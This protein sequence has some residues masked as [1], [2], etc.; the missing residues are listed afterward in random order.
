MKLVSVEL[1]SWRGCVL[2]F[3]NAHSCACSVQMEHS[4]SSGRP[5]SQ[6][7]S[8]L[9][10][11]LMQA[12]HIRQAHISNPC[13]LTKL[14]VLFKLL[15]PACFCCFLCMLPHNHLLPSSS[16]SLVLTYQWH[17]CC[18]LCLLCSAGVLL[19]LSLPQ[20]FKVG[21]RRGREVCSPFPHMRVVPEKSHTTK[22]QFVIV[23]VIILKF[24]DL[25]DPAGNTLR[26]QF[27]KGV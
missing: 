25:S 14:G 24:S 5:R 2:F 17:F 7:C 18:H 11:Q 15:Q 27:I 6:A 26:V 20:A 23:I 16:L 22:F 1:R 21:T 19:L 9:A 3:S 8:A 4:I 10:Y 13:Q 12:G